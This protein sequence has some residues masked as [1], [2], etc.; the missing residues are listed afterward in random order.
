MDIL[1]I[2]NVDIL[3]HNDASI[4]RVPLYGN[5]LFIEL[6]NTLILNTSMHFFLSSKG[7]DGPL[8]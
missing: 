1:S 4:T 6:T 5:P 2:I 3:S 8:I 7:F